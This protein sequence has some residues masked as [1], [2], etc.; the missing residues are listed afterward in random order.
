MFILVFNEVDR[1]KMIERGYQLIHTDKSGAT[2]RFI[3]EN[4]RD[5]KVNFANEGI[6][7]F[8]TNKI[9]FY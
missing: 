9:R 6:N 7:V 8:T 2:D 3:F 1:D 5:L 4:R